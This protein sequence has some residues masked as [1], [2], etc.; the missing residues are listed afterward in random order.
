MKKFKVIARHS[1][2]CETFIEAESLGDAHTKAATLDGADFTQTD[3]AKSDWEIYQVTEIKRELTAL[4]KAFIAAMANNAIPE[5]ATAEFLRTTDEAF[6]DGKYWEFYTLLADCRGV[7][8]AAIEFERLRC[9]A[10]CE[11]IG[12]EGDGQNCADEIKG[13]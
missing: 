3:G 1:N 10:I 4:E 9:Y 13:H 6:N 11:N 12:T 8:R 2:Y 5:Q 7:W